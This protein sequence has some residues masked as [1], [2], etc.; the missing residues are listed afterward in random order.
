[1]I[2]FNST[3]YVF[4]QDNVVSV[5]KVV[6]T[7]SIVVRRSSD[8]ALLTS[9]QRPDLQIGGKP[10]ATML[11]KGNDA[12]TRMD[13]LFGP[14]DMMPVLEYA[15]YKI[16][17]TSL[18]VDWSQNHSEFFPVSGCGSSSEVFTIKNEGLVLE[19][20]STPGF[21][22]TLDVSGGQRAISSVADRSNQLSAQYQQE[23]R[24]YQK[25]LQQL[26]GN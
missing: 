6:N 15:P 17:G 3:V 25:K 18:Y 14:G 10:R 20:A 26:R 24:D 4:F 8:N 12:T 19:S 13:V 2:D 7:A 23:N 22:L 9:S 16:E 5:Y 21:I 11:T 1:M